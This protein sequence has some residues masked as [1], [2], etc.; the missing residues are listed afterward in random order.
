M[1]LS[2]TEATI[3]KAKKFLSATQA[4]LQV[5]P[6]DV[7]LKKETE[8]TAGLLNRLMEARKGLEEELRCKLSSYK[9]DDQCRRIPPHMTPAHPNPSTR[10]FGKLVLNASMS[11]PSLAS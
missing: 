9:I 3:S 5:A 11:A 6:D 10:D 8:T 7:V 4:K 1:G 2:E